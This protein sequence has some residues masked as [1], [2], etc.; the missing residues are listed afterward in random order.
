MMAIEAVVAQHLNSQAARDLLLELYDSVR[1]T[2]RETTGED[3]I[4]IKGSIMARVQ[5]FLFGEDDE[6]ETQLA[7]VRESDR[8]GDEDTWT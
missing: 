2:A 5:A 1:Q 8:D 6:D 3:L 7:P 4:P